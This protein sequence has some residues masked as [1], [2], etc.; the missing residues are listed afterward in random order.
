MKRAVIGFLLGGVLG[1][2]GGAGAMLIA[3]PFIFPPPEVNE[4]VSDAAADAP[5]GESAF[6]EDVAGQDPGHWGKGAVKFYRARDGGILMELQ[7]DFEV[8]PGPN[9]WIYLN[10]KTGVDDEAA[11]QNDAERIKVAKLKSFSGSQVYALDADQFAGAKS[12]T[13]WCDS[14]NQY[15]AS[16]DIPAGALSFLSEARQ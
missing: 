3:F 14:F 4:T 10:S 1:F 9:F 16:A 11:F 12:V 2:G 6:R 7:P 13:I 8:G 5:L 15:I